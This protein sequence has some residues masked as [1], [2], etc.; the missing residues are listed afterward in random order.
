MTGK[1]RTSKKSTP[2]TE[3]FALRLDAKLKYLAEIASRRQR[4]SLANFVEWAV[5]RALSETSLN[6]IGEPGPAVTAAD[7][8]PQLWSPHEATRLV[9][10]AILYPDL[11]TYEEQRIWDLLR[12]YRSGEK[13]RFV[14]NG[15]VHLWA[16]RGCW[17]VIKDYVRG[18][19][20]EA[21]LSEILNTAE[22]VRVNQLDDDGEEPEMLLDTAEWV[23]VNEHA[24]GGEQHG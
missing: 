16:V 23:R 12:Q 6:A 5:E 18:T 3:V 7:K 17:G 1:K 9:K 21:E 8:A 19:A 11:L 4:R 24:D 20:T 10:L 13:R 15:V 2:R 22:W 14:E